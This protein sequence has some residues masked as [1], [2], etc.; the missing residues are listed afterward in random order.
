MTYERKTD[1]IDGVSA[2][3]ARRGRP[4]PTERRNADSG[5]E[6]RIAPR[7]ARNGNAIPSRL[8]WT[9]R[10]VEADT[11]RRY[12][13]FAREGV[14]GST[15]R[16]GVRREV[17][18]AP[19]RERA[20]HGDVVPA[21]IRSVGEQPAPRPANLTAAIRS[22]Q[23]GTRRQGRPRTI[24]AMETPRINDKPVR[25]AEVC[26][27]DM[28]FL[29]FEID[30]DIQRRRYSEWPVKVAGESPVGARRKAQARGL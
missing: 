26:A 19:L 3:R 23:A 6:P 12:V 4:R 29:M 16:E 7:C 13:R 22:S 14:P 25:V 27:H 28:P 5:R 11:P 20:M 10:P 21:A 1:T 30:E 9:P 24:S 15:T 8:E 17:R 2:W 18:G